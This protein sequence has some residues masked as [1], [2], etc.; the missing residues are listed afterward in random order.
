MDRDAVLKSVTVNPN[1]VE[2]S[3]ADFAQ[4]KNGVQI[5]VDQNDG[6]NPTIH[7]Q[8]SENSPVKVVSI[9]VIGET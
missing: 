6:S 8:L 1:T 4:D 2:F 3:P 9:T 5:P 7:I